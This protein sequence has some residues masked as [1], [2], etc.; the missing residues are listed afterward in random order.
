MKKNYQTIIGVD[1]SKS[2]LDYCI[3]LSDDFEKTHF[4]ITDNNAKGIIKFITGIKKKCSDVLFCLENT[5]V[6]SMPLCYWLQEMEVDYWVVPA[7][8]IKRSKGICRGKSDK[9][10]ARDI[11]RFAYS[12]LHELKLTKLPQADLIKL[13][14]L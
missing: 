8:E 6:Y 13:R 10:D 7:L 12:H 3:I 5:G 1:V 14:L 4:H 11:A 2:K 9:A